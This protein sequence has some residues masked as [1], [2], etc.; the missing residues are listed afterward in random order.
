MYIK[1]QIET[2]ID[3]LML[4]FPILALTGSRQA[5]KTTLMKQHFPDFDYF[6]LEDPQ[7]LDL[8]ESDPWQFLRLHPEHLIIDEI[9][10]M[11]V[12]MSY[13][14]AHVDETQIMGSIIISGSQNLLIS[15]KI[16]QSL[17][18]RAAYIQVLPFSMQEI[19]EHAIAPSD[20]FQQMIKG[21]YPSMYARKIDP[22]NYYN[23]YI[24]TYIERDARMIRNITDLSIFRKFIILLAGRVGQIVNVTSLANETGISQH[25]VED[26]LSILEASY[27]IFRLRPY[28]RNLSK[29][30]IR[31]PKLYFYDT[32]LLC[33]LLKVNTPSSLFQHFAYGS[34]F[35]NL[36]IA[37]IV[38]QL[39]NH[40][41]HANIWFF[42]DD[43]G[44]EID[45]LIEE[46]GHLTPVEIKS[47]TTFHSSFT[48]GLNYWRRAI[49]PS[50]RGFLVYGGEEQQ[51]IGK[52]TLIP[53]DSA[54]AALD[55][56]VGT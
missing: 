30:M 17:A 4:G 55:R 9:Q 11:P 35:E 47:S 45:I 6:N 13:L 36:I 19:S 2:A 53:W 25:T 18:G 29:R 41:R 20:Q 16:S 22:T 54:G 21:F 28:H 34:L 7:T 26:W 23:Q 15:E 37:E 32:G 40:N 44:H 5:G 1:R 56:T 50:A 33:A 10:R 27:L 8:V 42:R 3:T 12:L 24:A 48:D 38:K 14:Q 43:H 51:P 49:D 52:D 46:N 31:S 39:N